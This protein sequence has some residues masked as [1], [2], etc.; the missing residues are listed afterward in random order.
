MAPPYA[1]RE[2]SV[3]PASPARGASAAQLQLQPPFEP[4]GRFA[5]VTLLSDERYLT[6][7]RAL[8]RSAR[9]HRLRHPLIVM[10][11]ASVSEATAAR[12]TVEEG[13]GVRRVTRF[14]PAG[15]DHSRYMRALYAGKEPR[16]FN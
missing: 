4:R 2:P 5:Y 6:G 3:A 11:T 8:A 10:A 12:L 1:Q 9:L 15:V 14:L 13:L 16:T 7:V